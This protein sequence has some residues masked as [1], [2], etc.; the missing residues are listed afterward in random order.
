MSNEE[1]EKLFITFLGRYPNQYD[2]GHHINKT[3][4]ILHQELLKCN[5]RKQLLSGPRIINNENY[6]N[7]KP[8]DEDKVKIAIGSHKKYYK[9]TLPIILPSLI[10]AGIKKTN[11]IVFIAGEDTSYQ[12]THD[13]TEF[14][15]LNHNSFEN[16]AFIDIAESNLSSPFL[17]FIHDTCKVGPDFKNLMLNVPEYVE[18]VA[19]RSWQSMSIGLYSNQYITSHKEKLISVKN[20][21]YE[22][23]NLIERKLWGIPNEDLI[24]WLEEPEKT[25]F[26]NT[27]DLKVIDRQNWFGEKT[28]RLTEYHSNLDLYKSKSDW[29]AYQGRNLLP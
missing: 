25:Y 26:Y 12:E 2:I 14:R 8:I 21:N 6:P 11:I 23:N 7:N 13:D 19:L 5:E 22:K 4:S 17:F 28:K 29:W 3:P 24:L 27:Y 10:H 1:I 15:F 9:K 18:K 20:T 16:S